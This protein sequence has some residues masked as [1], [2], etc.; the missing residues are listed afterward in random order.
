MLSK[1]Q[2]WPSA[3]RNWISL[4]VVVC[5][6]AACAAEPPT[7]PAPAPSPAL[8]STLPSAR[9]IASIDGLIGDAACDSTAQCHSIGLG[10]K[11]CGGPAGY[12]AWS[13]KRT[14]EKALR[15]LVER[16]AQTQREAQQR[17][18][19]SSNCQFS[20]DPGARCVPSPAGGRCEL[21]SAGSASNS[22]Q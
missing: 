14:D 10:A 3:G 5:M 18:G 12:R 20:P 6:G 4:A 22:A 8:A 21:N 1:P 7:A 11:P 9:P 15:L 13:S 17:L 16:E 2:H 19:M